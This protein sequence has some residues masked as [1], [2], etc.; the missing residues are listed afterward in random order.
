MRSTKYGWLTYA[1]HER[2]YF[3]TFEGRVRCGHIV[4]CIYNRKQAPASLKHVMPWWAV[5][6]YCLGDDVKYPGRH[7]ASR[8]WADAQPE[9][10]DKTPDGNVQ[11]TTSGLAFAKAL[12][13]ELEHKAWL[14]Y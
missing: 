2:K 4:S 6:L 12:A 14:I 1:K 10:F 13:N 5:Y 3:L 11:P 8:K 7:G 9:L